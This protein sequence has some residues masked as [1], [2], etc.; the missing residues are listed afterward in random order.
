M[1]NHNLDQYGLVDVQHVRVVMCFLYTLHNLKIIDPHCRDYTDY[2]YSE[3]DDGILFDH[4]HVYYYNFHISG[5]LLAPEINAFN[6]FQK[7]M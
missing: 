3:I 6:F 5:Y 7:T 4:F 2:L 1:T